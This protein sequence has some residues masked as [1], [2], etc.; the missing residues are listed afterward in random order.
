MSAGFAAFCE[1]GAEASARQFVGGG[2]SGTVGA[3]VVNSAS[4]FTAQAGARA[5]GGVAG[6]MAFTVA[7]YFP[8]CYPLRHHAVI[9]S[10]PYL[11]QP[12]NRC[13]YLIVYYL[14]IRSII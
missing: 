1:S 5:T 12:V 9:H 3:T 11:I 4:Q 13:G 8:H 2:L 7:E 6:V 10:K 14:I